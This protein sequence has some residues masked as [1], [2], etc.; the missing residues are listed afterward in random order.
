[1]NDRY[2]PDE[3]DKDDAFELATTERR[4][5]LLRVLSEEGRTPLGERRGRHRHRG[6]RRPVGRQRPASPHESVRL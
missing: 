5:H 1:M 6:A 4:R 2:D 3:L